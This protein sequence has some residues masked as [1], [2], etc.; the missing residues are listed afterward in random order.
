MGGQ[1]REQKIEKIMALT[2]LALL[3]TRKDNLFMLGVLKSI[4][5]HILMKFT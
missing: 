4:E 2:W 3:D 1:N 5:L